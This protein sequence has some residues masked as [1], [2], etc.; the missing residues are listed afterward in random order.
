M[1]LF[2]FR[3]TLNAPEYVTLTYKMPDGRPCSIQIKFKAGEEPT[4]EVRWLGKIHKYSVLRAA[5]KFLFDRMSNGK[6]E[7]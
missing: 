3:R 1:S 5:E 7:S 4:Y 2:N 6:A